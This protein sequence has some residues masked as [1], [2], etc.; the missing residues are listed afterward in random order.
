MKRRLMVL[1]VLA[2][3]VLLPAYGTTDPLA[4]H[5]Q[6]VAD[7]LRA[8][9]EPPIG[10]LPPGEQVFRFLWLRSFDRPILV[11]VTKDHATLSLLYKALDSPW[12]ANPDGV[13]LGRLIEERRTP[14]TQQAWDHLA[15]MRRAVFWGHPSADPATDIGVDGAMWIVE[16]R[17]WDQ[18]HI[19]ERWSP[20]SGSFRELCLELLRLAAVDLAKDRVY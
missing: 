6:P 7:V 4:A 20:E 9:R 15:D 12:Y 8:M 16:G 17:S 1:F 5:Q 14:V 18:Y 2:V 11:Q 10:E 13:H 3:C 19:V